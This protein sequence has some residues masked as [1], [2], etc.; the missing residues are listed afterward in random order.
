MR[1]WILA[2]LLGTTLS[3]I[4]QVPQ[5]IH[6]Q[7]RLLSGTNLVNGTL[8]IELRLFSASTG[9][10]SLYADSNQVVVVD[11]LYATLIGDQ[12]ISGTLPAAL[13]NGEL[14]VETVVNGTVLSPR[15]RVS[16]VAYA[17][18]ASAVT[19]GAITS[20]ML[21]DGSVTSNKLAPGVLGSG[22]PSIRSGSVDYSALPSPTGLYFTAFLAGFTNT[23][24]PPFTG[25]PVVSLS[26]QTLSSDLSSQSHLHLNSS[27][28]NAFSAAA[29][30]PVVPSRVGT[31]SGYLD[32]M[33]APVVSLAE[34]NGRP[35][36]AYAGDT[37]SSMVDV[38][39]ALYFAMAK[40]AD[41]TAWNEPV[42]VIIV[43]NRTYIPPNV[44]IGA[45]N[46][47]P[48]MTYVD[49]NSRLVFRRANDPEGTDWGAPVLVST[50]LLNGGEPK[51]MIVNGNPAI[52]GEHVGIYYIRAQDTNGAA[53]PSN[54]F[55]VSTGGSQPSPFIVEDAPAVAYNSITNGLYYRRA[56]N[57][58]GTAWNPA[59]RVYSNSVA[60]PSIT[61]AA[62]YPAIIFRDERNHLRIM[63]ADDS[64]GGTWSGT[65]YAFST[66]AVSTLH[67][68]NLGDTPFVIGTMTR[69]AYFM[70]AQEPSGVG[71]NWADMIPFLSDSSAYYFASSAA[72]VNGR[73]ALAYAMRNASLMTEIFY[74]RNLTVPS[75]QVNWIAVGP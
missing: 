30:V 16:S 68:G 45:V 62:T 42:G 15:E 12:T 32:T 69:N 75:S 61:L 14:W 56:G 21:A 60:R 27:R 65:G 58:N 51:I 13:T 40:D 74:I 36:I 25:T 55:P 59:V 44:G 72:M 22:A 1:I 26:L 23:F 5:V 29:Y 31:F 2:L 41:G 52:V 10:S 38:N 66:N 49:V 35:A 37:N 43:S 28:S 67:A 17:M 18:M 70:R 54:F 24:T 19:T 8:G 39:S 71:L 64:L 63:R 7:G 3:A 20:A 73:P 11:G 48:A 50:N 57:L 34:V 4:A 47:H 33:Y 53:W 46:G 9:G 6:Y